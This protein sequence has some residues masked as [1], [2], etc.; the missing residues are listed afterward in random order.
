MRRLSGWVAANPRIQLTLLLASLT[1]FWTSLYVYVPVLPTYARSL[2]AS[3][4]VVGLVVGAYGF[5]QLVLRIPI[6]L[7][8]DRWGRRKP[9]LLG[10]MLANGLGAV[11]LALAPAAWALV[12]ARAVLGAGAS[13]YVVL[14]IYLVELF[15]RRQVTRAI[16]L[17]AA[18]TSLGQVGI[19]LTGGVVAEHWGVLVTFWAGVG[20]ALVGLV[21]VLPLPERAPSGGAAVPSTRALVRTGLRR[22][23]LTAALIAALLQYS[24]FAL[25]YGFVPVYAKD[26]GA[27]KTDL[28]ILTAVAVGAAAVA[29]LLMAYLGNRLSGRTAAIVGFAIAAVGAAVVPA[30]QDLPV[31]MISQ[32]VG[33]LGRGLVFPALMATSIRQVPLPERGTAMGVFQAVYALGMFLGPVTAGALGQWLG[34]NQVFWLIAATSLLGGLAAARWMTREPEAESVPARAM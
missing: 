14:S 10:G 23:V 29:A 11:M 28:G 16:S 34:L 13:T 1:L 18:V 33:G 30:I 7:G 8:S 2:G 5:S 25:T 22:D 21:L 12:L 17:G 6:G 9:F 3:L 27:S 19:M 26:I 4:G 24:T 15:P 20:L 32:A 31:L